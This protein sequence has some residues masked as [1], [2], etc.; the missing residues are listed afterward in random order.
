MSFEEWW[1][2]YY[3]VGN[4]WHR[5]CAAAAWYQQQARIEE[6]D[7]YL[8]EIYHI[9]RRGNDPDGYDDWQAMNDIGGVIDRFMK[10]RKA[11][12]GSK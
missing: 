10:S 6:L 7:E 12:E 1:L 11:L 9:T 8:H 2:D 4:K 3:G 5:E